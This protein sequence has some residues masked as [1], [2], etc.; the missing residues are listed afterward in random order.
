MAASSGP[1]Y[2]FADSV[3]GVG[4]A[5]RILWREPFVGRFV[6][7]KNQVC[8][9]GVQI[10]PE[11][12]QLGVYGVFLEETAAEKRVVAIREHARVWVLRKILFEPRL[13]R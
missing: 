5:L 11:L 1:S 12:L 13:L 3:H 6:S 2:D 8:V 10:F 7:R 9:G 4:I